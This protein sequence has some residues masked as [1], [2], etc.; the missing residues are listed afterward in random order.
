MRINLYIFICILVFYI[1][2]PSFSQDGNTTPTFQDQ[3][4]KKSGNLRMSSSK[5]DLGRIKN[6]ET[7]NDTIRLYNSGRLP[8]NI[9]MPLKMPLYLKVI[10][11][12]SPLQAGGEGYI[13]LFYDASKKNDFGFVLDRIQ[14]NTD[15]INLPQKYFTV[16]ANIEEFF[17]LTAISDTMKIKTRIPEMSF[18]YGKLR[19][20]EKAS[21][22][23]KIYNNGSKTLIIRKIKTNNVCL[24][25]SFSKKEITPGDSAIIRAEFD[26]SGKQGKDSRIFS[27]YINN[28]DMPEVK[29]E[30]NGEV[31]R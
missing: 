5:F 7:R 29:F 4:A 26:S 17:P 30:M 19:Q 28:P 16:T 20:G 24:K 25:A 1:K 22:D 14:L 2:Y 18:T 15:D 31:I 27:L 9:T 13:A 23:F 11:K 3:F 12:G 8:M 10:I 21:H 6:N